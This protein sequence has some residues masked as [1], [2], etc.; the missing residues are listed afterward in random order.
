MNLTRRD[1]IRT[2]L[3]ATALGALGVT[4]CE[5]VDNGTD[6][7]AS[8][9]GDVSL[10]GRQL[11][12]AGYDAFKP[13]RYIETQS[14]GSEKVV[15]LDI[16]VAD[17][18]A[19]R[20]GFTYTFDAMPFASILASVQNQQ[21][22]FSMGFTENEEREQIYD[23]T[24]GYFQ[25]RVGVVSKADLEVT[26]IDDLKGH[27]VGVVTGTVQYTMAE[28]LLAG[29]D[30]QSYDSSDLCLQELLSG[31]IDAYICD[32]AEAVYMAE[33][34]SE[35]RSNVLD[36]EF[37]TEYL[38]EYHMMGWKGADF[39]PVFDNEIGAMKQDGTLDEL[40]AQ[41]VGEDFTYGD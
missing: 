26:S 7:A 37:S 29:E 16:A 17:E 35:L 20:L 38:G 15:G 33:P 28:E 12:F 1:A 13:F 4:G 30:I 25:P 2:M 39:I 8:A 32:G 22:D 18:L 31:R 19:S 40:I 27:S 10:E 34:H 24:Q 14:D 36:K 5:K 41:W 21:A 23:F 3:S 9:D 11:V 6:A